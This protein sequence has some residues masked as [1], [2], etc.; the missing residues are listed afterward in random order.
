MHLRLNR[1]SPLPIHIQLKAQ[2]V[3]LIQAG[4]WS[5]GRRLP[6]VRQ[7]AG[8]LRIN[9][10]TAARVFAELAREGHLSCERGRGTFVSPPRAG[11]KRE[12]TR[13]L[14]LLLDEA[15]GRARRLGINPA[16]FA[17][18][19]Y[20]RTHAWAGAPRV[21][22]A[23]VL[24][25]ECDRP[26][27]RRLSRELAE[28]LPLRVDSFLIKDLDRRVRRDPRSLQKYPPIVT[29][30]FHVRE[31]QRLMGKTGCAVV[32]L[33][34]DDRLR[35]VLRHVPLVDRAGIEMLRRRLATHAHR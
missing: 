11:E 2:L 28:A 21:R 13:E 12:R 14:L 6:T 5:P 32:G 3:H 34:A 9:R 35:R 1:K 17:A 19:L 25:V 24:A 10:N 15:M 16:R 27:L 30:F 22:K 31:V 33:P 26:R 7:L 4:E 29:T 8:S 18:A 23:Q 20:A